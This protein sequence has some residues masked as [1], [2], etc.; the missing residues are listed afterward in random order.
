MPTID[1]VLA[2]HGPLLARIAASV[3]AEPARR[4]DLLQEI[5]LALWRALPG[6]R[7][8]ASLRSFVARIAQNRAVEHVCRRAG[9]L[10]EPLEDVHVDT[11]ADPLAQAETDERR[12]R[13]LDAIRALPIGRRQAVVL[14]LEGFSQREIADALGVEENTVAQRLSRARRQLRDRLEETA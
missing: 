1:E 7:G 2:E 8:E 9:R 12:H 13:L 11:G 4:Q 10:G 14:A 5:A 3:E 6:W